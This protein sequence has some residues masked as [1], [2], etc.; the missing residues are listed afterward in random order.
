MPALS[1]QEATV[2][3]QRLDARHAGAAAATL[4]VG[5]REVGGD[6]SSPGRGACR[7]SMI[8]GH[9]V[10][11]RLL[12]HL[13]EQVGGPVDVAD[14]AG[15]VRQHHVDLVGDVAKGGGRESSHLVAGFVPD[16]KLTTV[17]M[18]TGCS[19]SVARHRARKRGH[20]QTGHSGFGGA[21][22]QHVCVGIGGRVTRSVRSS[23]VIASRARS[24]PSTAFDRSPAL[25]LREPVSAGRRSSEV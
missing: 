20:T 10:T 14:Q 18:R 6:R 16:G 3:M 19:P 1:G 9:D 25:R 24:M 15:A 7:V 8:G 23:S 11:A 12:A 22:A 21:G 5:D 17:A 13:A 2:P 4:G